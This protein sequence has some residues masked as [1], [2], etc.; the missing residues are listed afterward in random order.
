MSF[1]LYLNICLL[2]KGP[3]TFFT[4][5]RESPGFFFVSKRVGTLFELNIGFCGRCFISAKCWCCSHC[6]LY[7][8]FKHCHYWY[9]GKF[10]CFATTTM[11]QLL[12]TISRKERRLCF[13]L[14]LFL[15]PQYCW[16]VVHGSWWNILE[17]WVRPIKS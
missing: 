8:F 16:K 10:C 3:G 12:L 2:R 11:Y 4:G 1:S 15:C 6:V 17:V 7:V 14:G 5:V 9:A 13:Y